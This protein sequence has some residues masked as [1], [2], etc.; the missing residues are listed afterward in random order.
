M[1]FLH[2]MVKLS[3]HKNFFSSILI[4][5]HVMVLF[6]MG[7]SCLSPPCAQKQEHS[8]MNTFKD[9]AGRQLSILSA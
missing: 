2:S 1:K 5:F 6:D 4:W 7:E 8:S 9:L 3:K